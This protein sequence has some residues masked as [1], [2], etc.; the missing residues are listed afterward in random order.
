MKFISIIFIL[1]TVKGIACSDASLRKIFPIASNENQEIMALEVHIKRHFELES[2]D[3]FNGV[4][5]YVKYDSSF[6]KVFVDTIKSRFNQNME[7][8]TSQI[9]KFY[10][11]GFQYFLEEDKDISPF[12]L[13]RRHECNLKQTCFKY[14]ISGDSLSGNLYLKNTQRTWDLSFIADSNSIASELFYDVQ[15]DNLHLF[16]SELRVFYL[17]S[18]KNE[19]TSITIINLGKGDNQ[20]LPNEY[21]Q[22]HEDLKKE[23]Y[24]KENL[25]FL[26]QFEFYN[27]IEIQDE[28]KYHGRQFDMVVYDF[29][30]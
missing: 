27:L 13:I 16:E 5:F 28:I 11:D 3:V 14:R 8:L 20:G 24:E 9:S 6:N 17:T 30:D 2:F 29:G 19:H 23:S 25:Y 26:N 21:I 22:D 18:Y 12:K 15:K 1:I 4:F 7:Q 10:S